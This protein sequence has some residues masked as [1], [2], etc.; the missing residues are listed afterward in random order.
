MAV[1]VLMIGNGSHDNR[2]CQAIDRGTLE[3]L[4]AAFGTVEAH[5][6]THTP[7]PTGFGSLA[8]G[9]RVTVGEPTGTYRRY[10]PR[11]ASRQLAR[12]LGPAARVAL[13]ERWFTAV[14]TAAADADVVLAVG[15]DNHTL[16]YGPPD[17]F[18][19]LDRAAL[20]GTP[21]VYLWGA[22]VG[23]FGS[24]PAYERFA[25]RELS[26][27]GGVFAREP[28]TREYLA[29]IGVRSPVH[30][31]ADPAFALPPAPVSDERL[32]FRLSKHAVGVN[33]S[34][35]LARYR[36]QTP[37]AWVRS[38]TEVIAG[39]AAATGRPVVLVPHVVRPGNDDH[40][41]L[42]RIRDGLGPAVSADVVPA[43]LDAS[44]L[45]GTIARLACFAGARTHATIAAI[46]SGVPTVSIAYS[47]KAR[48]LNREIFGDERWVLDARD[49]SASS[50]A[51]VVQRCLAEG[52]AVRA[53]LASRAESAR[54]SAFHA[55]VLLR[56]AIGWSDR[57]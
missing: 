45:K 48:G 43:D 40:A 17:L 39:L 55:G 50:L 41:L 36:E 26:R 18:W 51:D 31:V 25:A 56:D 21:H 7:G 57:A 22:S 1:R 9:V 35:L 2:G 28:V 11:W 24:D 37:D 30:A 5:V 8:D 29:R 49:L 53:A 34:P 4:R 15:G 14:R 16:D 33:V 23:P 6:L 12:L 52:D 47:A 19:A 38:A 13:F 42:V 44:E 27:L 10:S 32:G 20:G 54:A 46:S 3:V